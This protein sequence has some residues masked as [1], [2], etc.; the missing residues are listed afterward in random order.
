MSNELAL[1]QPTSKPS[2]GIDFF[3]VEQFNHAQRVANLFASSA[4][5]P[6]AFKG[7]IANCIIALDVAAR[8]GSSPMTTMQNLNII[9][10]KPSWSSQYVIAAVNSSGR[11]TPLRYEMTDLGEIEFRGA[12]LRN[13]QCVAYAWERNQ[14]ETWGKKEFRLE[15]APVTVEIACKE[16]WYGKN[17]SKWTS[18]TD[19]MLQYRA[20]TWFGRMYAPEILMGMQTQEEVIDVD[21]MPRADPAAEKLA[22]KVGLPAPADVAGEPPAPRKRKGAA[23]AKP[24]A[25]VV[26]VPA[27]EAQ[28]A[29]APAAEPTP[30]P[31]PAAQAATPA[32]EPSPAPKEQVVETRHEVV[33]VVAVNG[34]GGKTYSKITLTSV[35]KPVFA[36]L[37][38]DQAPV[39]GTIIDAVIGERAHKDNPDVK[40]NVLKNWTLVG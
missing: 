17:G 16:G 36:E 28:P 32:T 25:P 33:E 20:A 1:Q 37:P 40:I 13:K 30:E 9:H 39:V 18:M 26:T 29:P 5:A 34:P 6:D 2:H 7:N 3:N 19:L 22:E 8:T 12:K 11:F 4:L 23:A 38:P 21:V 27:E 14:P 35:A 31:A 10:G 15:S 24:E